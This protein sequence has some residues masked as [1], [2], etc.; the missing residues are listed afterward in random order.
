MRIAALAGLLLAACGGDAGEADDLCRAERLV[1]PVDL[2]V[3]TV[4]VQVPD[5]ADGSVHADVRWPDVG[6]EPQ[7]GWPI[8]LVLHGAWDPAGTPI[9]R[10]SMRVDV[11]AGL[12]DI[13]LDLPG[14]GRTSG[15]NDRRG[16]ASRA[17]VAA[18]LRW[19]AGEALDTGGCSLA[20][21][22]PG[23]DPD[24]LYVVGTSNG[25][26]LAMATLADPALD[27]P[28]VAGL[29]AWETPAGP[30]FTN[31]ELGATPSVYTPGSCAFAPASGTTCEMPVERLIEVGGG[32]PT[33]CFDV[34]EDAACGER[35]VTVRGV[36]D[37]DTGLMM[38]SPT[39]RAAAD[40]R[41]LTL[42]GYASVETSVAWWAERDGSRL[43][44][45]LVAAQADLP[46]MLLASE[47]DHVQTLADH[48][49]I[50]GLGEALQAAGAAWTR[51]NPGADWLG[52]TTGENAPN[53]PLQL[54]DPRGSLLS[55]AA[56]EPTVTLLAAAVLELS[57]R[58]QTGD[59]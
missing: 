20:D 3:W 2:G 59:W 14:N 52:E 37:L 31:V 35:D 16:A 26:N 43:A 45:P 50:Y 17:A 58:S 18:V 53:M 32:T 11:T 28:P 54:A 34:D 13:H 48:P 36:E 39:L 7:A 12:V 1:D 42:P 40:E 47:A 5:D 41:G 23:G 29:V 9:D 57:D 27:L 24:R 56:E 8:A 22:I 15:T 6:D 30:Q 4:G 55:E 49:H 38:L 51:L 10:G 44:A 25:G 33:L 19:A 21:R 46:V